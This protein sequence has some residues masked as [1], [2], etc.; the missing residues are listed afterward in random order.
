M[1]TI[2]KFHLY[3]AGGFDAWLGVIWIDNE[4]KQ[5]GPVWDPQGYRIPAAQNGTFDLGNISLPPGV[6]VWCAVYVYSGYD[7][8][9]T[10]QDGGGLIYKAGDA[11]TA[12]YISHGTTL[13][14][15][16]TFENITPAT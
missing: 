15:W 14:D 3:N 7:L 10:A 8:Y 4:G 11:H 9:G 1:P 2:S 16:L 13:N 5:H 6:T 12:N